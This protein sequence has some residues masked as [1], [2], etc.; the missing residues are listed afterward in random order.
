MRNRQAFCQM[1]PGFS[2]ISAIKSPSMWL[3]QQMRRGDHDDF[4][5]LVGLNLSPEQN[6]RQTFANHSP[7]GKIAKLLRPLTTLKISPADENF[8]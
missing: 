6:Q 2:Q 3:S 7:K 1:D 4:Q 8:R 5:L